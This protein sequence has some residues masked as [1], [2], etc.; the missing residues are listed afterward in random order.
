MSELERA[1][2]ALGRDLDVPETPELVSAVLA[3]MRPRRDRRVRR[4][5]SLAVAFAVLAAVA[6]TLLIPNARSAVLRF[7]HIG[8]D[9]I[10][11]V[12]DLPDVP[13]QPDLG[14]IL[15]QRVSLAE[16]RSRAGFPLRE[17]EEAPDGVYLGEHDTV[18]FLYG[19]EER[20]GLLVA[21]T[22]D[23]RFDG[24]FLKKLATTGTHVEHVSVRGWP[25]AFLSGEPH[26]V[27]LVGDDGLV[28]QESAR[29]AQDVL[30]WSEAGVTYRLEGDFSLGEALRLARGLR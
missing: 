9:E 30:V 29:L 24:S 28:V 17:L 12:D 1:L 5:V 10:E 4:R 8:G 22:P 19:T 26:I 6:G 11:F 18:W 23:L 20:V 15:G 7:L 16:A 3:R 21:Q 25:G 27:Y 2:V 14:L 13:A